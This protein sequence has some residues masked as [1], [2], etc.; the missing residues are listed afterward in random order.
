MIDC[1]DNADYLHVTLDFTLLTQLIGRVFVQY[2]TSPVWA[3]NVQVPYR[4]IR[5]G[6]GTGV[7][8]VGTKS[9]GAPDP[10]AVAVL[11]LLHC[12][13]VS[14]GIPPSAR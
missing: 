2:S 13:L 1:E 6:A 11:V 3:E 10:S 14:V 9:N 8:H 5:G 4:A 7:D 12:I